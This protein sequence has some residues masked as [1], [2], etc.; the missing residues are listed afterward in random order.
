VPRLRDEQ[1]IERI[2]VMQRQACDGEP[3]VW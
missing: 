1:P 3:I 2:A